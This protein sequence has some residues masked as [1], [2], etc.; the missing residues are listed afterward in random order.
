VIKGVSYKAYIA[1]V[2]MLASGRWDWIA[3]WIYIEVFLAFD[4]A[5][6]LV[7]IPRNPE[8]LIERSRRSQDV[9]AWDKVIMPIAS[10]ILPFLAGLLPAWI[11]DMVGARSAAQSPGSGFGPDH[12]RTC[13]CGLGYGRQCFFLSNCAYPGGNG[14]QCCIGRSISLDQAYGLCGRN[15]VFIGIPF[16]LSSWWALIPSVGSLILCVLRTS[17]EDRTLIEELP[18]YADYVKRVK[19]R[20]ISEIW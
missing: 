5:S 11:Y 12:D 19:I 17:L 3:G 10:G 1:V 16:L 20:L 7:V 4:A 18:G 8:L 6:A 13:H 15:P 2:L 9:K 14:T